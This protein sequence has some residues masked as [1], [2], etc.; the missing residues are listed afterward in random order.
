MTETNLVDYYAKRASEYERIYQK[1]ERQANLKRLQWI[2]SEAFAGFDL[3]EIACGTGYWTQFASR[4]AKSILA[5]DFNEEVLSIAREK[6]YGDCPVRFVKSDAFVMDEVDGSFSAALI[7]F[8]WSHV[9]RSKLDDFLQLLH[10]KLSR[11]AAIIMLDNRYV[12]GS[13]TPLSRTDDGGNTY[14]MR[15]LSDGSKYEVL[16]NFPTPTEF[17][18]RIEPMAKDC[19]FMELDYYWLAQYT[20]KDTCR[21]AHV[22]DERPCS[23]DT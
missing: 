20:L 21:G 7:A 8:W 16:K 6:D 19:K 10:S 17:T 5:T 2:L 4:S 13:S 3:L 23:A 1:P 11:G 12:D 22:P 15:K 14:Q 9:P 18:E